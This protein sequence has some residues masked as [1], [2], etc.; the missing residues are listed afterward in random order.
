MTKIKKRLALLMALVMAMTMLALPASATQLETEI[1]PISEVIP[2]PR[3]E[4]GAYSYYQ[5]VDEQWII[6]TSASSCYKGYAEN[7][8][9]Y[10]A[11]RYY[12]IVCPTCGTYQFSEGYVNTCYGV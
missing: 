10:I 8:T 1:A 12:Y 7:H 5:S 6:V 2:C 4:D 9:H 3:C 11:Y